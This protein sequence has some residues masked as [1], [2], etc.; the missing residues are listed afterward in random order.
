[1]GFCS[2][3]LVP[4]PACSWTLVLE[5][6][7]DA[8]GA[9]DDHADDQN[10]ASSLHQAGTG[11][12]SSS[13]GCEV[14]KNRVDHKDDH[15]AKP[16]QGAHWITMLAVESKNET[17]SQT[18]MIPGACAVDGSGIV[19]RSIKL[20]CLHNQ[21]DCARSGACQTGHCAGLEVGLNIRRVARGA[22]DACVVKITAATIAGHAEVGKVR[23]KR[24]R[25]VG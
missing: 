12:R 25:V 18:R 13:L 7:P 5:R 20:V 21:T 19:D 8:D 10:S 15:Q 1:M 6:A 14:R 11:H 2:A 17:S 23:W 9:T 4:V 22:F 3:C 16:N 24:G